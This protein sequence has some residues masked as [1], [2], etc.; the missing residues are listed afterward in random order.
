MA[1]DLADKKKICGGHRVYI[2]KII[3][4]SEDIL[5]NYDATLHREKIQK[6]RL[7]LT[8]RS[9]IIKSLDATIL[10]PLKIPKLTQK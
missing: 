10:M 7:T 1:E 4:K 9:D 6:F 5:S 3:N 8:E 2:T